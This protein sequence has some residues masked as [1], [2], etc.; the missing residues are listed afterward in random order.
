MIWHLVWF[1]GFV[2]FLIWGILF[3]LCRGSHIKSVGNK[4]IV[5]RKLSIS[6]KILTELHFLKYLCVGFLFIFLFY[7]VDL[8]WICL[9]LEIWNQELVFRNN[10][11]GR[12]KLTSLQT[13]ACRKMEC[14]WNLGPRYS[15][16]FSDMVVSLLGQVKMKDLGGKG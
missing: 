5:F 12:L 11:A 4:Y 3:C 13:S 10:F 6:T 8:K 1:T 14:G 9:V 2:S 15:A 7:A 16:S